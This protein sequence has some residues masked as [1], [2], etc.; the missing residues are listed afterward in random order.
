VV[1]DILVCGLERRAVPPVENVDVSAV[2]EQEL[3]DISPSGVDCMVQGSAA[4]VIL[5][6]ERGLKSTRE[7]AT[8]VGVQQV[9]DLAPVP[10]SYGVED[11]HG[12][13]HD[14]ELRTISPLLGASPLLVNI[15]ISQNMHWH[16]VVT[17]LLRDISSLFDKVFRNLHLHV[18]GRLTI[19][20]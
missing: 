3:S 10:R 2:V 6:V 16:A 14:F 17:I 4:V 15:A 12:V 19:M 7:G 9:F 11:V 18:F 20:P 1:A 5:R 13:K 8:P